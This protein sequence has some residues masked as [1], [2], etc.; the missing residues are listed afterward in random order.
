[1]R[2]HPCCRR[3]RLASR[4]PCA[5]SGAPLLSGAAG[6]SHAGAARSRILPG[7]F[8]CALR[9]LIQYKA[10]LKR[11]HSDKTYP[12]R[13]PHVL[14]QV[15]GGAHLT[16]T[17]RRAG[18][19]DGESIFV[20]MMRHSSLVSMD[21]LRAQQAANV[22][23]P[24][25]PRLPFAPSFARRSPVIM[26]RKLLLTAAC[27]VAG[28]SGER[29]GA[30]DR[31]RAA[32]LASVDLRGL[33]GRSGRGGRRAAAAAAL[34]RRSVRRHPRGGWRRRGAAAGGRLGGAVS[35]GARP[36]REQLAA[37][38]AALM[39]APRPSD[40]VDGTATRRCAGRLRGRLVRRQRAQCG[41]KRAGRV[42]RG[43][44][45]AAAAAGRQRWAGCSAGVC[46]CACRYAAVARAARQR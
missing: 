18:R 11:S 34:G 4:T 5:R 24:S 36:L 16:S 45:E 30:P 23:M 28:R 39:A 15:A 21:R 33:R 29:K 13:Y 41:R 27:A 9:S 17:R 26:R 46:V 7:P 12:A 44:A 20:D 8:P 32:G 3:A 14:T 31:V 19:A 22:R 10:A 42:R 6:H 1:M 35:L 37:A 38:A 40:D 43:R 2:H 25:P